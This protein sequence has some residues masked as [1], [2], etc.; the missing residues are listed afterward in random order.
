[1][2][3][4][5]IS[6]SFLLLCSLGAV[7]ADIGPVAAFV[8]HPTHC[9][10]LLGSDSHTGDNA[11][12]EF[13]TDMSKALDSMEQQSMAVKEAM[14]TLKSMCEAVASDKIRAQVAQGEVSK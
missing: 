5:A 14:G 3:I 9:A 13:S 8:T 7:H 1:M 4:K 12:A 11:S 10:T 6:V 2:A